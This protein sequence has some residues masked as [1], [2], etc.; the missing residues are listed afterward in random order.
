MIVY[1][2]FAPT[3]EIV[4]VHRNGKYV[5]CVC[6]GLLKVRNLFKGGTRREYQSKG[7]EG[8]RSTCII[9]MFNVYSA[10]ESSMS[11]EV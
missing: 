5:V 1:S 9:Y 10:Y 11:R 4:T 3:E 6:A 2:Y 7:G 8:A